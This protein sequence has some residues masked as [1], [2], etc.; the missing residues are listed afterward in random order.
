MD[1]F[2]AWQQH[3]SLTETERVSMAGEVAAMVTAG[4]PA[5]FRPVQNRDTRCA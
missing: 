2:G 4:S 1:V 3:N 5:I